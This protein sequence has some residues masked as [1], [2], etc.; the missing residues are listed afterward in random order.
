MCSDLGSVDYAFVE[1]NMEWVTRDILGDSLAHLGV[2]QQF[3]L[4]DGYHSGKF[5]DFFV[6][7]CR[8]TAV[9]AIAIP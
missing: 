5:T 9:I 6:S 8:T 7:K 3:I 2:A 4:F 1:G